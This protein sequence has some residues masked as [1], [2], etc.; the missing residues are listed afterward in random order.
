M[1]DDPTPPRPRI[2]HRTDTPGPSSPYEQTHEG[3]GLTLRRRPRPQL[4]PRFV[5]SRD[6]RGVLEHV[7]FPLP[8][9]PPPDD[10]DTP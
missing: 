6:A 5:L 7:S 9:A 8:E 10:Q 4:A 1:P 3:G 2:V